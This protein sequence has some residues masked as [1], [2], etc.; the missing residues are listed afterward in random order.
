MNLVTEDVSK[1]M[2]E[3]NFSDLFKRVLFPLFGD[4]NLKQF[5]KDEVKESCM[6]EFTRKFDDDH[7]SIQNL[8]LVDRVKNYR[9]NKRSVQDE[10]LAVYI[11]NYSNNGLMTLQNFV[12]FLED[13]KVKQPVQERTSMFEIIDQIHDLYLDIALEESSFG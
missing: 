11:K 9:F 12:R 2:T 1:V 3:H 10:L 8:Q 4:E 6:N 13:H 7:V 5:Y